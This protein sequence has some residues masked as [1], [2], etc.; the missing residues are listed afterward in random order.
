MVLVPCSLVSLF[1]CCCFLFVCCCLACCELGWAVGW[2]VGRVVAEETKE[3]TTTG[4]AGEEAGGDEMGLGVISL[5]Y[6]DMWVRAPG[7]GWGAAGM[8]LAQGEYARGAAQ[9]GARDKKGSTT[10]NKTNK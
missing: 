7:C 1:G 8:W 9:W 6:D 4:R 10:H 2:L 3:E 5:P